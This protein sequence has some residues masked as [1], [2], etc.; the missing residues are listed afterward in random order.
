MKMKV[1]LFILTL[2]L[3]P[4]WAKPQFVPPGE[5]KP[6]AQQRRTALVIAQVLEGFHYTRPHIDDKLS[7]LAFDR[8]LEELDPNRIFF[9]RQDIEHLSKYR[10]RLDDSLVRGQLDPAYDIFR[11]FRKKVEQRIGYALDLLQ[12]HKFDFSR[13]ESYTFD[14]KDEP[15]ADDEAALD[16]LW[17]KRVKN[18]LL[19]ERLDATDS[20][21]VDR[22]K[23]V[24]RYQGILDRV[25]QM[26]S[27]DVF[28][29][30]VNAMT[31]SIEPHTSYMS[32]ELSENFDISMRLSLQGIGAVLRGDDG[33][34]KIMSTVVGGPA[35]RSG[36]LH[37]GDYI[38]GVAQGEKD[39]MEDVV[40]W[41]LQDV[42]ELIRGA[43]GSVVR[44]NVIPKSEGRS[45]RP[46]EVK[47]VRDTIKLEDKAA[48]S[49]ILQGDKF[50][51]LKIG[52]ID[53]PAFY[54]DFAGQ[55]A[56][57]TNFRS[58]TRD[59]K[60]LLE[61][62]EAKGVD[63]VIIDL[64]QDGGG[65]LAEATEL[66][67]L[68]ID[69]GPVVQIK[70]A[71][72]NVEVEKDSD[73]E[74]VYSGPLIVLVNRNSASASE[75]F[76]GAI[77]DY[78][79]GLIVGEPTF[80]KGTVQTLVNLSRYLRTN[81][82]LGRL[83]LTMA[84]FFRVL[85]AST[86]HRG[87]TPDITFPTAQDT[88]DYGERSLDHAL[89]W[90]AIKAVIHPQPADNDVAYLRQRSERRISK[91][92]GFSY[93]MNQEREFDKV[94]DTHTVSL[95]EGKRRTEREQREQRLLDIRNGLRAYR[96]LPALTSL[97][98]DEDQ[99]LADEDKDPEGVKRIM[100]DETA[101]IMADWIVSK[102]PLTAQAR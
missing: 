17:R 37:A 101:H 98:E 39:A 36:K 87:V 31:L 26:K 56:G 15:W 61:Q 70:D 50:G 43:K 20:K 92:P 7:E 46:R 62:L 91:D 41:R 82:D 80:G 88:G 55:A 11:L 44:L 69:K 51:G 14:R 89:P 71:A 3:A 72:G 64:R 48:K 2:S 21:P 25:Q 16:T 77:Q 22:D 23:L 83:R 4:V 84:Q 57:K 24:K 54:R 99:Q 73:P 63:G 47:L 96:G 12:H 1:F 78:G 6:D 67:G 33:L 74:Q 86:Q 5:L 40:G 19:S 66:T 65:S 13:N 27:G 49:E 76:A 10:D 97:D 75:I 18:D 35:A 102:Q 53:V 29:A 42:V 94:K 90:A 60:R 9:T 59:V 95:N 79:R 45:G 30:F 93:L 28:Q 38:V 81:E 34:T 100:L 52:V 58:T 8:Y 85:G 68:F 32:P